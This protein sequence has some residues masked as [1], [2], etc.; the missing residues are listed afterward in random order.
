MIL[1]DE[2]KKRYQWSSCEINPPQNAFKFKR[3]KFSSI[4]KF[5]LFWAIL[6]VLFL[7]LTNSAGAI[8][9]YSLGFDGT[10][11]S[12][13]YSQI[14]TSSFEVVWDQPYSWDFWLY[15]NASQTDGRIISKNAANYAGYDMGI[16]GT[17]RVGLHFYS[18]S[19]GSWLRV[20]T[21]NPLQ[22][23]T[24]QHIV[25][26]YDG[27]QFASGV[28]IYVNAELQT[29]TVVSNQ[30]SATMTQGVR[31]VY[32]GQ[33]ATGDLNLRLKGRIDELRGWTR[34]LT[35]ADA[36]NLYN[37]GSGTYYPAN[38]NNLV[39]QF[40]FDEGQ[41]SYTTPL[42]TE[43]IFWLDSGTSWQN[44]KV[45]KDVCDAEHCDLCETE[46]TCIAACGALRWYGSPP[47]CH[48]ESPELYDG[49]ITIDYP[50]ENK[51]IYTNAVDILGGCKF[52]NVMFDLTTPSATW[53]LMTN[54]QYLLPY[55]DN[56]YLFLQEIFVDGYTTS[57]GREAGTARV[58]K[59]SDDF[60]GYIRQEDAADI[61]IVRYDNNSKLYE[62]DA[63]LDFYYE[64]PDDYIYFPVK[65]ETATGLE[66]PR[67]RYF[68][69][70]SWPF[71]DRPP[72][73]QFGETPP[74]Y[75]FGGTLDDELPI[76]GTYRLPLSGLTNGAHTIKAHT[77]VN[78]PYYLISQYTN[79]R[80]FTIN[81]TTAGGWT[82]IDVNQLYQD[83]SPFDTPSKFLQ[84]V[85][86]KINGLLAPVMSFV[87]NFNSFF[88]QSAAASFANTLNDAFKTF[89]SYTQLFDNIIG[90]YPIT[91]GLLFLMLVYIGVIIFNI[92]QKSI[93]TIKP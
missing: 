57:T 76:V 82:W 18:A 37:S 30:I 88:I 63:D 93:N 83:Y 17:N 40:D 32:L 25:I 62:S 61:R 52:P 81:Y 29:Q 91:A 92:I 27:T 87:N 6:S 53:Q 9:I 69:T 54:C 66:N 14:D 11:H 58:Y 79:D 24:W 3:L 8:S 50:D 71:E 59:N 26:A 19:N 35:Q 84:K 41:G 56:R 75:D 78:E 28:T 70:Y 2:V 44:G 33:N 72:T 20:Y 86:S 10:Y 67:Y 31:R 49:A 42:I 48:Q 23:T 89:I 68:I 38:T 13:G 36:T 46:N 55:W 16:F 22:L 47:S 64:T 85:L 43:E 73:G 80:H 74:D 7:F 5:V 51:N 60:I 45:E 65:E 90:G 4:I 39:Y 21:T 15:L 77:S 1:P 12:E 34:K